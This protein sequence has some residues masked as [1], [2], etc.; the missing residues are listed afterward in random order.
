MNKQYLLWMN[1]TKVAFKNPIL[2][3]ED[4]II[5]SFSPL[6]INEKEEKMYR[7]VL[8]CRLKNRKFVCI[9]TDYIIEDDNDKSVLE[10]LPFYQNNCKMNTVAYELFMD[11]AFIKKYTSRLQFTNLNITNET[12]DFAFSS[13]CE[14]DNTI[15]TFF[16]SPEI[17]TYIKFLDN[18]IMKHQIYGNEYNKNY[19]RLIY[20][21]CINNSKN[22]SSKVCVIDKIERV[23][24][25]GYDDSKAVINF[26]ASSNGSI[27][28]IVTFLDINI[29]NLSKKEEKEIKPET[30]FLTKDYQY[31]SMIVTEAYFDKVYTIM[32]CSNN[33]K[34]EFI[35]FFFDDNIMENLISMISQF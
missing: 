25:I 33:I 22:I 31:M 18:Y 29:Y 16:V 14:N 24:D 35:V 17:F 11:T 3:K 28:D 12:E 19:I 4:Y 6:F 15:N 9:L 13:F 32:E 20:D 23:I 26:I 8:L 34:D 30:N 27:Y 1:K 10:N 21:G 5:K 2:Y 7:L